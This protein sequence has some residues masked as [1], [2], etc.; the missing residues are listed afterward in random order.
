MKKIINTALAGFGLSGKAFHAPFL[1]VHSGF[2]LKSVLERE[3]NESQKIY[4][5]VGVLRS[6]AEIVN[7]PEIELVVIA[8]P[9]VFHY[10]MA[11]ECLEGGKHVVIEKPFTNTPAEAGQLIELAEAK[12]LNIF[13]FQ[14]RRWDGDFLTI[15]KIIKSGVLGEIQYFEAH[16][17]RY[18]PERK[19]ASWRDEPLPGSGVLYDLGSHLIDQALTLFG[20]PLSVRA[21]LQSQREDSLVDDFFEV[22]MHYKSM[23][24]RV[25]AGMLVEDP[26]PRY[27]IHGS[28]GS[29]IKYG[30]DP[31]ED[32]LRNGLLPEGEEWGVDPPEQW[33]LVT[34]DYDE[35]NFDGRIETEPGNYMGFYN[36]V[37][38]VLVHGKP[39][40]VKP[41]EAALVIRVIEA[42]FDSS[43]KSVEIEL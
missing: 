33:G 35:L 37:Y 14:N 22:D 9:N 19:R 28:R 43:K 29:F 16:F 38:D 1:H 8:T 30:I 4:P 40:S 32:A 3:R 7:D 12:N 31:Q 34:F 26:G 5:D 6:L 20:K 21:E 42:A 24:A 13:V 41:G 10:D 39:Q 27:I 25:T 18:T 11:R 15:R 2:R 17:D 36:N 23:K